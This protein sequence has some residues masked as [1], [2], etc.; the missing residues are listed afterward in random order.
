MNLKDFNL[1]EQQFEQ[2]VEASKHPNLKNNP[3]EV[4]ENDLRKLYQTLV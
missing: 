4:T 1:N 2:L 3:I